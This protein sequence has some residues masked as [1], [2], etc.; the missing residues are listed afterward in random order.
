MRAR[1]FAA[2]LLV[3][4]ASA[5]SAQVP[6]TPSGTPLDPVTNPLRLAAGEVPAEVRAGSSTSTNLS[7][8]VHCTALHPQNPVG[9]TLTL[10]PVPEGVTMRLVPEIVVFPPNGGATTP[11][12]APCANEFRVQDVLVSIQTTA[13]VPAFTPIPLSVLGTINGTEK[14]ARAYYNITPGAYVAFAS[15]F[16]GNWNNGFA[17][18]AKPWKYDIEIENQG[19]VRLQ[20]EVATGVN[21]TKLKVKGAGSSLGST[22]VG[23]PSDLGKVTIEVTPE[24]SMMNGRY[25]VWANLT[26]TPIV[27]GKPDLRPHIEHHYTF[28]N[29]R[30]ATDPAAEDDEKGLPAVALAAPVALALAAATAR[31]RR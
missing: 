12:T 25:T 28:V 13:K 8:Q 3:V 27:P 21:H 5:A 31:R 30:G 18:P 2:A 6:A 26:G 1:L 11:P 20:V 17:E 24:A 22:A 15:R 16:P 10:D 7:V 19:N 4:L 14:V 23:D 29:V 9:V